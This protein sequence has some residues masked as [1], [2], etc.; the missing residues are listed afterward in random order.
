MLYVSDVTAAV[1]F[2]VQCLGFRVKDRD[3]D[4]VELS[5]GDSE[6]AINLGDGQVKHAGHQTIILTSEN[7]DADYV[8]LASVARVISPIENAPYGRTFTIADLDG[9]KIEVV[10][11]TSSD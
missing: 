4:F 1:D 8:R 10:P 9:N 3:G 5:L 6:I 11:D 2:Y 7:V